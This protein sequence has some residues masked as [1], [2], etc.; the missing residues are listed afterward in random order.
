MTAEWPAYDEYQERTDREISGRRPRA[1]LSRH[2]C[3]ATGA[4]VTQSS[5]ATSRSSSIE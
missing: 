1:G 5:V 4:V 3:Q 2:A